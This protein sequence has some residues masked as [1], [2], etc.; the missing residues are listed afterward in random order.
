MIQGDINELQQLLLQQLIARRRA[1]ITELRE[2]E[3]LL[4]EC[5][6]IEEPS[7]VSPRKR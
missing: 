1:L 2:L 7:L 4:I 6:M 5:G 3:K